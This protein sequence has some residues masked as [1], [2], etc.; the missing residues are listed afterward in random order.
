MEV[1]TAVRYN[2][3]I[4]FVVLNNSGIAGGGNGARVEGMMLPD[5]YVSDAHYERVIEAFGGRGYFVDRPQELRATLEAAMAEDKPARVNV[6]VSNTSRTKP[7]Q[8]QWMS[9]IDQR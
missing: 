6:I 8:F 4:T 3:P 7:Q 1:E 5:V 2:L 9:T